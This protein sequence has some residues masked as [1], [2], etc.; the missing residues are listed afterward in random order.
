MMPA[1]VL[2]AM[3]VKRYALLGSMT[4]NSGSTLKTGGRSTGSPFLPLFLLL[5]ASSASLSFLL[6]SLS[7]SRTHWI[8]RACCPWFLTMISRGSVCVVKIVPKSSN[9]MSWSH[10]TGVSM[11]RPVTDTDRSPPSH[12]MRFRV[13]LTLQVSSILRVTASCR[14]SCGERWMIFGCTL[15][16]D[17]RSFMKARTDASMQELLVSFT[18]FVTGSRHLTLPQSV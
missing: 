16:S 18:Y 17:L 3:N 8:R 4:T 6:F 9:S 11:P 1:M 13:S 10:V 5:A 12:T 15:H 2:V 14:V 7:L